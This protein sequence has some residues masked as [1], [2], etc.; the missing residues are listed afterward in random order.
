MV[1][2]TDHLAAMLY[3]SHHRVDSEIFFSKFQQKV[4][5]FNSQIWIIEGTQITKYLGVCQFWASELPNLPKLN[6]DTALSILS[7]PR[8]MVEV[9]A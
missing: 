6:K 8:A 4:K 1:R 7:C 9:Q 5:I 2:F 3:I